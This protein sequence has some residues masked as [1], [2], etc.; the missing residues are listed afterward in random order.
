MSLLGLRRRGR[1]PAW[2]EPGE[3]ITAARG[4]S[5]RLGGSLVLDDV[6][7]EVRAGEVLALVGPNGAGKSTLLSAFAGDV[8]TVRGA[9]DLHGRR[10]GEWT[11][12]EAAMRRSVLLQQV[13]LSFPFT[14]AD[15][16]RMGRAPWSGTVLEDSDDDAVAEAM[17]A[18]DVASFA[19]RRFTSLSG[20]ERAR[21]ALA[22]VLAQRSQLV[23]L[24]EPTAALDLRHQELVLSVARR[25]AAG[26]GAVVVVLHDLN[27]AGAHADRVA[28]LSRGRITAAGP[29]RLVFTPGLLSDVY[30]HDIQVLDHPN[31]SAPI[32]LPRR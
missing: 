5:V 30:A 31:S 4:V 16:V 28:V 21:V 19:D 7:L 10:L 11:S 8:T 32:I 20:G 1:L 6:S 3:I 17:A 9:V 29:P 22:R 2:V 25:H 18:T 13:T 12:S 27:V 23:F 15:V 14:V 26:G 24:D